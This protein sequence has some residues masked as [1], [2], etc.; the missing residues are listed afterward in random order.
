MINRKTALGVAVML[1]T[2]AGQ[3]AAGSRD[4]G[5]C[6]GCV[7]GQY[8]LPIGTIE[9]PEVTPLH[10]VDIGS[11]VQECSQIECFENENTQTSG[12]FYSHFIHSYM[13]ESTVP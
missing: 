7:A 1:V 12:C 9:R 8:E 4:T 13:P 5:S 2:I 10:C 3:A 11:G 6:R